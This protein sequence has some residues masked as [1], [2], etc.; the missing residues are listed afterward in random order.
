MFKLVVAV[1]L[2]GLV[3]SGEASSA[4]V[5]SLKSL[6]PLKSIRGEFCSECVILATTAKK[7]LKS[8]KTEEELMNALLGVCSLASDQLKPQVTYFIIEAVEIIL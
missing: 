5:P 6:L 2:V 1:L 7:A 4:K 3:V 8:D